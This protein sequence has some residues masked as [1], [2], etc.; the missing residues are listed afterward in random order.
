MRL[1]NAGYNYDTVQNRVNEILAAQN[2]TPA[3]TETKKTVAELAQEVLDAKW[4]NG[5]DRKK[6]L[7]EAGYNYEEVQAEVNRILAAKA[8]KLQNYVVKRGDTLT[9]IAN[10]FGTTVDTILAN[11]K[12]TYPKMTRNFIMVGWILR[13]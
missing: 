4:G 12:K 13:V 11:N 6:R 7:T 3:P 10:Q 1:T 9:K 8:P 2:P 5:E